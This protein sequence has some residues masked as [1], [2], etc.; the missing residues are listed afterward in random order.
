MTLRR[1]L[2]LAGFAALALLPIVI[3]NPY[4]VHLATV[5]LIFAIVL[6]GLDLIV[7][8][9]GEISLGHFGLFAIGAYAAGLLVVKVGV[10]LPMALLAAAAIT[11]G[12]VHALPFRRCAPAVPILPW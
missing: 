4:Y 2:G 7:G 5:V 9:V 6:F 8:Y 12:L 11:A 3:Q 10:P 1:F